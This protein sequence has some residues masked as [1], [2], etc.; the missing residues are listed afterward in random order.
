[1][2][3]VFII[4]KTQVDFQTLFSIASQTLGRSVSRSLDEVQTPAKAPTG[5]IAALMEFKSPNSKLVAAVRRPGF[6]LLHLHYTFLVV[7]TPEAIGEVQQQTNLHIVTERTKSGFS[8][9]IVTG[10]LDQWR[11]AII[12]GLSESCGYSL[13]LFLDACLVELDK[14]GLGPM[15]QDYNRITHLDQTFSLKKI[16]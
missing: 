4:G 11:S 13:R 14:E 12:N 10:S 7:S 9:S 8:V 15:F 3:K 2:I 1:M 16:Q 6:T 5:F